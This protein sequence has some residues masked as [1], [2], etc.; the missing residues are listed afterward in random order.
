MLLFQILH[1]LPHPANRTPAQ[2]FL[3]DFVDIAGAFD[4]H[5]CFAVAEF[6]ER[7][8]VVEQQQGFL[9]ADLPVFDK[10]LD[11]LGGDE[12]T[13]SPITFANVIQMY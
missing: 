8:G 13:I 12:K 3:Q 1:S 2:F 5:I 9:Q 4:I 11:N 10:H 7:L 6:F